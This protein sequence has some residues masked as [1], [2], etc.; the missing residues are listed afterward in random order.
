MSPSGEEPAVNTPF[1][2]WLS[3]YLTIDQNTLQTR[4]T[5][6]HEE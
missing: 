3:K 2:A 6:S 4:C 5:P 1:P